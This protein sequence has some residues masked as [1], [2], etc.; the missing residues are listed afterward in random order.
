MTAIQELVDRHL[1][2]WKQRDPAARRA[3]MRG[4]FSEACSYTDPS[5]P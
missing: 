3:G 4:V 2:I 1:Q 5:P